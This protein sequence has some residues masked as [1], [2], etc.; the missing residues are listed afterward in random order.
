MK[1]GTLVKIY[2]TARILVKPKQAPQNVCPTPHRA[3]C[4]L[5]MTSPEFSYTNDTTALV[6]AT[7]NNSFN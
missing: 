4:H 7:N 1:E 3:T 6:T 2:N 5:A